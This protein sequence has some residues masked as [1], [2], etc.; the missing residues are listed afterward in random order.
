LRIINYSCEN[1]TLSDA[2]KLLNR[3]GGF[4]DADTKTLVLEGDN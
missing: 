3:H 4:F 1:L 2:C